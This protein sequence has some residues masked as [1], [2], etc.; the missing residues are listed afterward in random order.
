MEKFCVTSDLG[1]DTV[2]VGTPVALIR[3]EIVGS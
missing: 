2:C 1:P 3:A